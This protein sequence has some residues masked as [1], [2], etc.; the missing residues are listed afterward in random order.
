MENQTKKNS[1]GTAVTGKEVAAKHTIETRHL[2]ER[3]KRNEEKKPETNSSRTPNEKKPNA[4]H[5][6]V[7]AMMTT[8]SI[9]YLNFV[10]S[11]SLNESYLVL[12]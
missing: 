4:H 9:N 7:F 8:L 2:S 3:E 11:R 10:M 1:G 6:Y 12:M 5:L